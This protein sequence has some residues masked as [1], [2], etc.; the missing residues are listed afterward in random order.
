MDGFKVI[1]EIQKSLQNTF[2]KIGDFL[3]TLLSALVILIIGWIIAKMI[4]WALLKVLRAVKIDTVADNVGIN[5]YLTKGGIK[6]NASGL[7]ATLGYWTIM[8]TVLTMFFNTLGLDVVSNLLTEVISYIPNIIV[9][10]LL[11]IVGMY[12]AEFVSGLV[13]GALKG[14]DFE[15][16]DMVGRIA[17]GAV[18]FFTIAIV[19][20]QLGIGQNIVNTVVT[21]I[22]SGAGL[23]FAIAFGLGGKDWAA[24]IMNKYLRK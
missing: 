10:C 4:K 23:A 16:P 9:A 2:G 19:L 11:L 18:M 21:V 8:F 22:M 7:I 5:G 20:D 24:G 1:D 15:N 17:Y 6:K 12:L 13:V 14:G 3:P